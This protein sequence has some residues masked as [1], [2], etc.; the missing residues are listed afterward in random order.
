MGPSPPGS[1]FTVLFL[2]ENGLFLVLM[3]VFCRKA[4]HVE[5]LR[6]EKALFRL[7]LLSFCMDLYP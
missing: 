7:Q 3:P 2:W 4:N 5:T 6:K 1:V